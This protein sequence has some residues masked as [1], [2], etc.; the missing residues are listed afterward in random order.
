MLTRALELAGNL[1]I[2]SPI[3]PRWGVPA[4]TGIVWKAWGPNVPPSLAESQRRWGQAIQAKGDEVTVVGDN[5]AKG[6]RCYHPGYLNR[7]PKIRQKLVE[8]IAAAIQE[9][10]DA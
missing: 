2:D 10:S 1:D 5:L 3:F 8:D 4:G 9:L 7:T 6:L